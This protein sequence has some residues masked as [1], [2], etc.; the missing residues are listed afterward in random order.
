MS[1]LKHLVSALGDLGIPTHL[2]QGVDWG[3]GR[4]L[5][6]VRDGKRD[7]YFTEGAVERL[8]VTKPRA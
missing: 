7:M 4:N 3:Y 1:H 8:L 2:V 6:G 5:D